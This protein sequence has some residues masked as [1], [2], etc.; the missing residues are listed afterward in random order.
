MRTLKSSLQFSAIHLLF[1]LITNIFAFGQNKVQY[2]HLQWN[3]I[4]SAHFK[5]YLHQ[6]Q[7]DLPFLANRMIEDAYSRLS[8]TFNFTHKEPIPLIIYGNPNLFAQTNIITEI[9]P[10]EVGGF[11]EVLKNRIAIPYNGSYNELRHVLHH[12]LVHAFSYGILFDQIGGNLFT[13]GIQ[14]PLWFMEGLAEYLSSKWDIEADMFL[15]DQTIHAEIPPPGPLLDGYMAYKGG[16]SFLHFLDAS[17]GDSAFSYFLKE[18][19]RSRNIETS[20][21]RIYGKSS[22]E[23]GKEWIRELKK[24]YWP[25][26][27]RRI[28]PSENSVAITN[29]LESHNYLN[30]RPRIA[31]NC[32]TIAFFSDHNDFTGILL[33]DKEGNIKK[34]ISQNGYGGFFES[35]HP[36][37]SGMCW[38]SDS[39]RL[40]FVTLI[41]GKDEI[42]IID[43]TKHRMI[44]TVKT[45]LLS[46]NSPDWSNDG[47]HLVFSGIDKGARDLY[48]YNLPDN[49]LIRLTNTIADETDP[50]FS[51]N[52]SEV[53]YSYQDTCLTADIKKSAYGRSPSDLRMLNINTNA[54]T[55]LTLTPWNEKQPCFS[56]DGNYIAYISD[57]NGIDNIYI[58]PVDSTSKAKPLTNYLGSSSNPDWAGNIL[59]FTLFQNQGWDVRLIESPLSKLK[60]DTLAITRWVESNRDSSVHYFSYNP[61]P[62]DTIRKNMKQKIGSG[63]RNNP[64]TTEIIETTAKPSDTRKSTRKKPES[65][66]VSEDILSDTDTDLFLDSTYEQNTLKKLSDSLPD[67]VTVSGKLITTVDTTTHKDSLPTEIPLSI[68]QTEPVPYRLTFSPDLVTFGVGMSTFYTPA[69]QAQISLSDVMGDHRI[70]VA[71]DIQGNFKDY[72]HFY[73]SYIYL[74][75]RLD[76]GIGGYISREY[77]YTGLF[78]ERLF[79]DEEISGFIFAQYPFSLISR[80][81]FSLLVNHLKRDPVYSGDTTTISTTFLPSIGYSY[82]NILWGITG[83]INGTRAS[84]TLDITP[85]FD[86]IVNP[87]V[88]LDVDIRHYLHIMKRFVWA[89]RLFTGVSFPL[90]DAPSDKRYFLG[91]NDNWLFY[92]IDRKEYDQNLAYTIHSQFVTPLRGHKYLDITGTRTLLLN[93]EFRFPFIKEISLAW[94]LPFRIQYINGALFFDAGNAWDKGVENNKLPFPDKL[95]GGFGFGMR[96]NLGIFVLRYDRGWPTDWEKIG[97]PI[98][99]F[100]LGAEF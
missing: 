99:Y 70:T 24:V 82:D 2:Q 29:H 90:S 66:P 32:S 97:G 64:D 71:G 100:S 77:S 16:Q 18:F 98:N 19:R 13:S 91:G 59:T 40:A 63:F 27:G 57:R 62:V 7:G 41:D 52:G 25:E 4:K 67:T 92:D 96:A 5:T 83:P 21:K 26:I 56:P 8:N 12:E 74:K 17:K 95:Y 55:Y 33:T 39:K 54:I 58:S 72:L 53:I 14:M 35:F 89:N 93:T 79:H 42:R 48:M 78:A 15:L 38:A 73:L 36:F 80:L 68:K 51:P 65:S 22:D 11:T 86:F 20:F 23:L 44:R 28:D 76:I 10:E 87:Y 34:S 47:D 46:I 49:S 61:I 69:G 45:N 75:E 43:I 50:R 30:L 1:S 37:R 6:D 85:P 9:L 94:P 60:K 88:S 84:V 3:Y 31:P 81:E